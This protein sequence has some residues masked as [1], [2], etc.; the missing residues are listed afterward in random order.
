MAEAH[1]VDRAQWL[2]ARLA[3]L[4]KEKAL[5]R[6]RDELAAER[7]A[8]PRLRIAKTYRFDTLEGE[9]SLADLFDGKSQLIVYHFML[10]PG[11]AE[12]C[13][14]C[15]FWAEQYDAL[16]VHLPH[17]DTNLVCVS[18]APLAEIEQVRARMGWR[19]PWVSSYGGDFNADFGVTFTPQQAGEALYNF[20]TQPARAGE[21][22]GLSVFLRDGG[23]VFHTYSAYSRGLDPLNGVY[24]LLDLTPRGRDEAALPWPMEWVR[25]KDRYE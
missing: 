15:S 10:A 5:T 3:L 1:E 14:S 11:A 12:P 7:A 23:E 6:L 13:K 22:P 8:M 24:Q 21:S 9:K 20:G 16:R 4:A 2:E 25:L 19:F 18:R 17:R